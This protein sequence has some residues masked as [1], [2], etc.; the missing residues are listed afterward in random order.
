MFF[1]IEQGKMVLLHAIMKKSQKTP[2]AALDLAE[3]RKKALT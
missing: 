1:C 2:S 3:Q